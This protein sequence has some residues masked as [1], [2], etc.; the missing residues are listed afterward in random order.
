MTK[1]FIKK[2]ENFTCRH[3]GLRV[4]G[5]GYTNHCPKC[6][7]SKHVDVNPGDRAQACGGMMR[8]VD[9]EIK[10]DQYILVHECEKC[11]T[12]KKNRLSKNDS[13]ETLITLSK[14]VAKKLYF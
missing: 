1:K 14:T 13:T 8:P 4:S 7:Y 11:G 10:K 12:R 5:T 6:L 3:C 9:F 2:T